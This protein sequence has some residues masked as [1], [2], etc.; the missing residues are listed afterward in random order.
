V[1]ARITDGASADMG[2]DIDALFKLPLSEFTSARN[3]IVARLKKA[4]REAEADQA[5]AL[6]K[7]S[8]SAWVV[9][10]L[11]WHHRDLFDRLFEAGE[12]LRQAQAA[13]QTRDSTRELVNARRETVSA[14]AKIAADALRDSGYSASRDI[15]RRVTGTLEALSTYG[16]QPDA[17]AAGRLTHDVEPPGFDTLAALLA[18]SGVTVRRPNVKQATKPIRRAERVDIASRRREQQQLMATA[19][20]AVR[21]A[22]RAHSAARK[23]AERAAAKLKTAATRAEESDR[24]RTEIEQRLARATREADAAREQVRVAEAEAGEATQAA[25]SAERALEQARRRLQQVAGAEDP[26]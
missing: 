5:K 9:N 23:Q 24:Q 3:A 17:P 20:E 12:R 21:K 1:R 6:S 11:Y 10:Q 22:E 7:P 13:Q 2:S 19:R 16:S 8:V 25:E 4:G 26:Y 18:R 15:M 14:L